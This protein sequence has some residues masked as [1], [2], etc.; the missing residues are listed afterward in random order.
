MSEIPPALRQQIRLELENHLARQPHGRNIVL[1]TDYLAHPASLQGLKA[2]KETFPDYEVMVVIGF[3]PHSSVLV[4]RYLQAVVEV[5]SS[6]NTTTKSFFPFSTYLADTL[7]A[8]DGGLNYV[9]LMERVAT[10][11]GLEG[12]VI[13]NLV[14]Q[15]GACGQR[16]PFLDAHLQLTGARGGP[17]GKPVRG[18]DGDS[19][20]STPG[21]QSGAAA[22]RRS[23]DQQISSARWRDA[24]GV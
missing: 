17:G 2:F 11:G 15:G 12:V 23:C 19:T 3:Q 4:E 14:R 10:F 20:R 1:A 18:R 22:Q 5:K 6:W 8:G 13:V 24:R 9:N 21:H 16:L 7:A